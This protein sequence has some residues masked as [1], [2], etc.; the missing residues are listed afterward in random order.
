RMAV[1]ALFL[2]ITLYYG[3]ALNLGSHRL[4]FFRLVC[5]AYLA[6]GT[7]FHAVLRNLKDLFNL[8]L[9]AHVSVDVLALTLLMYASGGLLWAVGGRLLIPLPAAALVAPRRLAL[10]YASLA[11]ISLLLEQGYWVLADDAPASSYFQPGLLA[12]GGFAIAGVT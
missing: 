9:S 8:Q 7:V 11:A 6:L 4:N 3:D 10:L 5:I 2:G 12:L 1:A